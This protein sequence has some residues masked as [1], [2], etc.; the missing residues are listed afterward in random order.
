MFIQLIAH[1]FRGP[2]SF[3][4]CYDVQKLPNNPD[5]CQLWEC[6][7]GFSSKS[8]CGTWRFEDWDVVE[9]RLTVHTFTHTFTEKVLHYFYNLD[10]HRMNILPVK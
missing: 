2:S 5:T 6:V 3:R 7:L 4:L 8:H 1:C 10:N 9:Y